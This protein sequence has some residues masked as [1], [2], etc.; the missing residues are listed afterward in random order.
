MLRAIRTAATG[1][2]AQ[3]SGVDNIANNL[4]NANTVG[5]K[6]SN[7]VF[8]DLLYQTMRAGSEGE[9][10]GIEPAALQMGHGAAAVATVRNFTQGSLLD[11]GNPLDIAL[12]GDGFLQ[13]RRPDGSIAY[14]RDGTLTRNAEGTLVTQSGLPIEPDIAIPETA[15]EIHISMDGVV[16]V[17]LQGELDAV[18]VGQIE[19]ARFANPAG[20]NP[21]GGNLYEQTETSGEPTIGTP[22]QDG[23]AVIM[24]GY[25]E[26]SNVDVV[27]EMVN[28]IAAQRTYELNSKMVTTGEEMLQIANNMKR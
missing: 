12:N 4:A 15:V 11:T 1:M 9:Q 14:T 10:Q 27:Q 24:Q 19:L 16:S 20:L 3:Q 5:Y 13:V 17:R 25:L 28:L 21:I 2:S 22:G 23:L 6:R 7:L 8:H 18:E 26:A